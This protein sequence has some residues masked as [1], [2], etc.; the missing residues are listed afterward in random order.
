MKIKELP[1]W[2]FGI[3]VV[4]F[5]HAGI[6]YITATLPVKL[7]Y[8]GTLDAIFAIIYAEILAQR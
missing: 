5:F 3:L 7:F 2:I 8:M 6:Y 1:F 4:I